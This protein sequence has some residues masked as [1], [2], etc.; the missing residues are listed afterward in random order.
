MWCLLDLVALRSLRHCLIPWLRIL[1]VVRGEADSGEDARW[2]G[3]VFLMRA[4][5]L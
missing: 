2:I 1:G 3:L 5:E 4:I